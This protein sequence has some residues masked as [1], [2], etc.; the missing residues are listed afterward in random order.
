MQN[1]VKYLEKFNNTEKVIVQLNN[2][3]IKT[4]KNVT[5]NDYKK[6]CKKHLLGESR[7]GVSPE[8]EGCKDKVLFG[9]IDID[10]PDLLPNEKY[11][12][13]LK[14]K[15]T[16][17]SE[18]RIITMIEMSKSKGFHIYVL[19]SKLQDRNFIKKMLETVVSKATDRKISN[20]EIEIFPKGEK[21]NAI[22]LPF[23][24]MFKDDFSIDDLYFEKKKSCFIKW[25]SMETIEKPLE[26]IEQAVRN[27]DSILTFLKQLDALPPCIRKAALNWRKGERNTLTFAIAGVLKKIS[28]TPVNVSTEIIK[29]IVGFNNDEELS[30]RIN[31]V[32]NTYKS[33]E[34]AGCSIFQCKNPNLSLLEPICENICSYIEQKLTT[35]EK[36]RQ[37]QY[38]TK[39]ILCKDK[40]A[41]LIIETIQEQGNVYVSNNK[42]YLFLK[43][44]KKVLGITDDSNEIKTLLTKWGINAAEPLFRFVLQEILA[45]CSEN[46]TSVDIHRMAYY[47]SQKYI[48]YLYNTQN[49]ILKITED[50]VKVIKNGDEG[51]LFEEMRDFE[52]FEL[53]PF[54]KNINY[55][56][57]N[58][59]SKL[60]L[61]K[62]E[63]IDNVKLLE[64]WFYS[65]FFESIMNTKP[66]LVAIGEKGSGKT[67]S[68][69]RLGELLMGKNFNVTSV[70]SDIKD[71]NTLI[72][73]N[74]FIVLDNMDS[75]TTQ[76]NDTLARISTGQT[77]K[78]RDYYTTNKQVNFDVKC[79]VA[80]TSRK[81][82][83]TRD[84]IADRLICI[85]LK[86]FD[87]F[88][89]ENKIKKEALSKRNQTMSYIVSELQNK[90]KN[91][92]INANKT[93]YT[94][95]R[96]ADFAV[97]ALS[98][99]NDE[100]ERESLRDLFT[101]LAKQQKDFA[102]Q[103]D[104]V[105]TILKE[106]VGSK[107]NKNR[108]FTSEQLYVEFKNKAEFLELDRFFIS[109][110]SNPKALTSHLLNIRANIADEIIINRTKGRSNAYYYSFVEV[111][112]T[113]PLTDAN[114][115]QKLMDLNVETQ[116]KMYEDY[117]KNRTEEVSNE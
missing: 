62:K 44:E 30:M 72:S 95:F 28:N 18:F 8:I 19:F 25:H 79:F 21:G 112:T 55:L 91:L 117:I 38:K 42:Y 109:V 31:A 102:T 81:P 85:F 82:Q 106:I 6:L 92:K 1:Y 4:Y 13:A 101:A 54:D 14:I 104:I 43:H 116:I 46:A 29:Q 94:D 52:P 63:N 36:V 75:P 86:R 47:D 74:Y 32:L 69:R 110:Y 16:A 20:G 40:I 67:S 3:S 105:Y 64:L 17:L 107:A 98:S 96:I 51:V 7:L 87:K 10:C 76:I 65:L 115:V 100:I 80:L 12:L 59:L 99:A 71:F 60:N 73:N 83:F 89:N 45:Y 66:L 97:F 2:N 34:I 39:G 103:D 50:A 24:G 108:R 114:A 70:S 11:Q 23:Y 77:L 57:L 53:V 9:A 90:I 113:K 58:I 22:F 88:Q 93:F 61:E 48:L 41:K 49:S 15:D 27:N 37:I 68:L 111:D 35:K 33:E 84:D 78:M 26:S 5:A 56:T